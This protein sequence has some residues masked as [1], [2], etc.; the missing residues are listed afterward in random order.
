MGEPNADKRISQEKMA[1]FW[2]GHYAISEGKQ[3]ITASYSKN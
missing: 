3:G 2:H 1:L